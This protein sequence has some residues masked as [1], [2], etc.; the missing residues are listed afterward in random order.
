MMIRNKVKKKHWLLVIGACCIVIWFIIGRSQ[1]SDKE[2]QGTEMSLDSHDRI[3]ILAPHPDDEVLGCGGIIQQAVKMKL[4]LRVAFFTYG[5]NNQWSFIVYR[6]RPVMIPKAV[7]V[8]GLVRHNEA[9][10]AA[11]VLGVSPE[12]L[13]FLGYPDFCTLEIWYSHWGARPPAKSMLTR[14]RKVPYSNAFRPGAPYK[15]EEI[16]QDLKTI[17]RDFKPTKI[18]L[19]HPADHNSDHRALY[20]FT[21][22]ALWDL[23]EEMR[24]TLYPYI[25]HYK[26]WPLPRGYHPDKSLYPPE[27]FKHEIQWQVHSLQPEEIDR[28]HSAIKK[29]WSQY[30]SSAKYLLSFI[31]SNEIFGDFPVVTL[32]DKSYSVLLVSSRG[33]S[34]N[35]MPEGLL[36]EERASFVGV[37]S[38]SAY[39]ENDNIV[40]SVQLSRPLGKTVGIS[41][42]VFG[43]RKDRVFAKMPKIHIRFGAIEHKI[44]DQDTRLPQ[45]T[46][47]VTRKPR[48]ITVRIPIAVLDNPQ[49]ILTSVRTYTGSVPLDWVEWRAMDLSEKQ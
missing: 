29:H 4:P 24:P 15:G 30:H 48:E 35:E 16:L 42:F 26:Q 18:F 9:I 33:E 47:K 27:L 10:A 11:K 46:I 21:R 17:L 23:E 13:T 25:I 41:V 22:V 38:D 6:K 45:E 28:K 36:D 43:Y 49:R 12:Q 40:F 39:L 5:D 20:L 44:F 37:E 19:S 31:R 3:L 34:L 14:V 7:R 2:F 8:M 32:K 1:Q